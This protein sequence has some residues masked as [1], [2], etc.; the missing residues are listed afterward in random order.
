MNGARGILCGLLVAAGAACGSPEQGTSASGAGGA[1]GASVVGTGATSGGGA[2]SNPFDG[3]GGG[4]SGQGGSSLP[5]DAAI[6]DVLGPDFA[7]AKAADA[8]PPLDG[9]ALDAGPSSLVGKNGLWDL[10]GLLRIRAQASQGPLKPAF[11][12]AIARGDAAL[13]M[14]P[15]SVMYKT[16]T[17]PSGDKHDYTGLARYFWPDPTKPDGLPYISRD[18]QSNPD[19]DSDKY[20]YH[21]MFTMTGAVT[22]L[23]LAYFLTHDEKYAAKAHDLL[24]T[25]YIDAATKMNPNL[26]FAQSV[27]GVAAGRKEGIIDTLQMANMIDAVEMLRDSPA[28]AR[29]DLDGL[30]AWFTAFLDWLRTSTFGKGEEAAANNHGSWYDV[31][32][33]RYA[34]FL[35][36]KDLAGQLAELAKSRRIA[37]Q[38]NPDG[39]LPQELS[40]TNSLFYSEYDLTA[41]FGIAQLAAGVGVDLFAYQTSDGRSIRK[42]LD[43]LAPYADPA[44]AWP[45]PQLMPDDRTQLIPLLRRASVAYNAPSYEQTLERYYAAALPTNVVQLVYPQ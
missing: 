20:D 32:T 8:Q 39:S 10:P 19:V 23:G 29:S 1:G 22:A 33:M 28:F 24:K 16:T 3:G 5:D 35:G 30:T 38:I 13:T 18:G 40:R 43:Y 21:S 2:G 44:K 37:A 27:P 7:D 25:W 14:G 41:L 34:V 15:F 26:N 31:Q 12:Q 11:D 9:A 42:A 6:L 45:N 4:A 17:P 36:N